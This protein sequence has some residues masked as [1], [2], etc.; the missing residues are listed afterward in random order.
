MSWNPE[1]IWSQLQAEH[2][3]RVCAELEPEKPPRKWSRG[4]VRLVVYTALILVGV[5]ALSLLTAGH[6]R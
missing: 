5:V 2:D 1:P 6:A 4:E 3:A